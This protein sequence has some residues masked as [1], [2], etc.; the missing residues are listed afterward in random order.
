MISVT[1]LTDI[2]TDTFYME[3][4]W[5][6]ISQNNTWSLKLLLLFMHESAKLCSVHLFEIVTSEQL[7]TFTYICVD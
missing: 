1:S 6:K 3:K 4:Q 5:I 7:T 2:I